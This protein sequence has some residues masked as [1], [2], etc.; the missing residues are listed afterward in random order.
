MLRCS[1]CAWSAT[2]SSS[3]CGRIRDY[4]TSFY[5][6][7][8]A[9]GALGGLFVSLV[10]PRLFSTYVEWRLGLVMGCLLAV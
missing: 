6:M 5:L 7:I 10:A 1:A 9:G 2:A 3:V 8:S 4:L